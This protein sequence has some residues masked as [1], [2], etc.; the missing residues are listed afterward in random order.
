MRGQGEE[1]LEGNV[2]EASREGGKDDLKDNRKGEEEGEDAKKGRTRKGHAGKG[3]REETRKWK[4][5]TTA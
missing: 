2:T 3:R 5:E 4:E 1:R